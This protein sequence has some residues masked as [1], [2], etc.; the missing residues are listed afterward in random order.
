MSPVNEP[1]IDAQPAASVA[2]L[3]YEAAYSRLE[4]V[5]EILE[6][7]DLSLEQSLALYEEG[8]L[9]AG[10][11]ARQLDTAELRVRRWQADAETAPF[12]GWEEKPG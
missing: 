11:C 1:D 2:G 12:E 10:H 7:G 6:S 8:S 4:H 9:L 5:L 3:S